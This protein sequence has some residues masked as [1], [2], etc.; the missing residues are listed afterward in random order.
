M[1]LGEWLKS[2]RKKNHMTMQDLADACGFSKAYIGALEKGINPSTGKPY[3]PTI[4]TLT[5]IAAGTGQDLDALL[6]SL[7][8][9]QPVTISTLNTL[10]GEEMKLVYSYR[11]L[12]TDDKNFLWSLIQRLLNSNKEVKAKS[13][14][15][16]NKGGS[17]YGV[18]G[19]NFNAG[20]TIG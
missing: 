11:E 4:Q 7:D 18:V 13:S 15:I 14:I 5:K 1:R 20:I 2:Y 6:K 9:D 10:D 17:N 12:N 8:G 16:N 3:S 19:G